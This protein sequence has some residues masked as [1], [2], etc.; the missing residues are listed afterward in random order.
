MG[1]NITSG[2]RPPSQGAPSFGGAGAV[3]PVDLNPSG[4]SNSAARRSNPRSMSA[5]ARG[6]PGQQRS[7]KSDISAPEKGAAQAH[8]P[9]RP[10]GKG[11]NGP[12]R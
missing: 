12:P 2:L 4:R 8:V 6:P 9:E 10:V 7:H 11:N 3:P 1:S 5:Q